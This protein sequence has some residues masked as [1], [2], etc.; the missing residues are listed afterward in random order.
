MLSHLVGLRMICS[1]K[2]SSISIRLMESLQM[3][4]SSAPVDTWA[5]EVTSQQ[6]TRS[7]IIYALFGQYNEPERPK[8][9]QE[10]GVDS[11]MNRE[12]Y[13]SVFCTQTTSQVSLAIDFAGND[14]GNISEI[15]IESS[16]QIYFVPIMMF[17]M[18]NL[19]H[20]LI[21]RKLEKEAIFDSQ[22][23]NS[24]AVMTIPTSVKLQ[25]LICLIKGYQSE[26]QSVNIEDPLIVVRVVIG[27]TG[28]P[29]VKKWVKSP[30]TAI[31]ER[32]VKIPLNQL[33]KTG[34]GNLG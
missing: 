29:L 27:Q 25:I 9:V 1:S 15:A 26:H 2:K 11:K 30:D 31:C 8:L 18:E 22:K 12:L 24:L 33:R 19:Q 17:R 10:T 34:H 7:C 23:V 4:V 28:M 13:L 21:L 3:Q 5:I 32:N 20:S 6:Q 14:Y 16:M